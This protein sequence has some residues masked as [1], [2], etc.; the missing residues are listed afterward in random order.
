MFALSSNSCE[1]CHKWNL[2]FVLFY[3]LTFS[4]SHF[5]AAIYLVLYTDTFFLMLLA[6]IT[7]DTIGTEER[8][9]QT[10]NHK[11]HRLQ[12]KLSKPG[13]YNDKDT[14]SFAPTNYSYCLKTN[15]SLTT[16]CIRISVSFFQYLRLSFCISHH[17]PSQTSMHLQMI[18][19]VLRRR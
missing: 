14:I 17:H 5:S 3:P 10:Y 16:I 6:Y 13:N 7:F 15:G 19:L 2:K 11:H 18:I 8:P 4:S 12:V 9:E 1:A